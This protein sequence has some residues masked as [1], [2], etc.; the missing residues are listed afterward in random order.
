M[1]EK[2][3]ALCA[4]LRAELASVESTIPALQQDVLDKQAQLRRED[5]RIRLL[6][7][8]IAM[9]DEEARNDH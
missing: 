4:S 3:I 9:E 6:T 5:E 7:R 8:L 1:N 2:L